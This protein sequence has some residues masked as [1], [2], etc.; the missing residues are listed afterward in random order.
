MSR[1]RPRYLEGVRILER[2]L[3]AE[4]GHAVALE[5]ALDDLDLGR[6]TSDDP[7]EEVPELAVG[8]RRIPTAG[9]EA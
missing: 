5:L 3:A 1:S 9:R 2:G 4:Q 7:G 6:T 8:F